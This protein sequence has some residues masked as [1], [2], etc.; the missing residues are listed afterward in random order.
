NDINTDL[1]KRFLM[2]ILSFDEKSGFFF[3]KRNGS[4]AGWLEEATGYRR[5]VIDGHKY[6]EHRI[7]WLYVYD[8]WPKNRIDHIDGNRS[9]NAISNLRES[10]DV[11]NSR[12]KKLHSNNLLGAKGVQVHT[13]SGKF[14]ARIFVDG[15]HVSLGLYKTIG[16]AKQAYAVAAAK[17]FGD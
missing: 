8:T 12:N 14:R 13:Q 2:E 9:N 15:K 17:F 5:I 10:S 3:W 16:E 11:E 7:A 1:N 6:Q 4:R